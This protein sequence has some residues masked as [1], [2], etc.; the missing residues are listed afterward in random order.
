MANFAVSVCLSVCE[1]SEFDFRAAAGL[2]MDFS[3]PLKIHATGSVHTSLLKH[4]II[5]C[6]VL[7]P[8][9][10]EDHLHRTAV[11]GQWGA[12][13]MIADAS[14]CAAQEVAAQLF[15][16]Q[17]F[18]QTKTQKIDL[19]C[20]FNKRLSSNPLSD[21]KQWLPLLFFFLDF[22]AFHCYTN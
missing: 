3:G 6:V 18:D 19:N 8:A 2:C 11:G 12:G 4:R 14:T 16:G 13:Q 22:T 15:S 17:D 20:F 7:P 1:Q 10:E 21:F 9:W 5:I